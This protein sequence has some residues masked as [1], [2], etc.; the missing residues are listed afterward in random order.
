[1]LKDRYRAPDR[2]AARRTTQLRQSSAVLHH[3]QRR[4]GPG[5]L[6]TNGRSGD[7]DRARWSRWAGGARR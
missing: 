7:A 2:A 1:M 3:S 4:V 6:A 5:Q